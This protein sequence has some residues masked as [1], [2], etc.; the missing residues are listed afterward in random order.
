LGLAHTGRSGK[1]QTLTGITERNAYGSLFTT[2]VAP[3]PNHQTIRGTEP[4]TILHTAEGV[5]R[6]MQIAARK[7]AYQ[8]ALIEG[9]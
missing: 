8:A 1:R 9:W 4:T 5:G 3:I 2:L 7:A 6:W